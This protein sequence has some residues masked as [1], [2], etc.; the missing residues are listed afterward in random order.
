MI[1]IIM[2]RCKVV[3]EILIVESIENM[4]S[5]YILI[6]EYKFSET[7]RR[8]FILIILLEQINV[9]CNICKHKM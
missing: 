3:N 2:G 1:I 5:T 6:N 9:Y 8:Y 7:Q 4:N